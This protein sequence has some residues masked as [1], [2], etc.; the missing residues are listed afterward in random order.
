MIPAHVQ[1]SCASSVI[2][3]KILEAAPT[4]ILPYWFL[5]FN[6]VHNKCGLL[7]SK[8]RFYVAL[9][10]ADAGMSSSNILV[11]GKPIE[12]FL[13]LVRN[14]LPCVNSP[15][16]LRS[17]TPVSLCQCSVFFDQS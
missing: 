1:D 9:P 5:K 13:V 4:E 15:D 10:S 6:G 11:L 8:D 12:Q 14:P 16:P 7:L 17:A 2:L 3:D